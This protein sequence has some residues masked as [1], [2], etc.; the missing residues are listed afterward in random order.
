MTA[1]FPD[2]S[3]RDLLVDSLSL[4]GEETRN[5]YAEGQSLLWRGR[6]TRPRICGVYGKFLSQSIGPIP[7]NVS[8]VNHEQFFT[9]DTVVLQRENLSN[10]EKLF[11]PNQMRRSGYLSRMGDGKFH[12]Q[13]FYRV[14]PCANR[15]KHK[16]K[17]MFV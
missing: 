11:I 7:L 17:N 15:T 14:L 5:P 12:R 4:G 8:S 1:P 2:S 16:Q 6:Q 3:G 10:I 9:L 13:L